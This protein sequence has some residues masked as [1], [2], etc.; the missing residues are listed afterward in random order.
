ML[1]GLLPAQCQELGVM[2][3]QGW[4]SQTHKETAQPGVSDKTRVGVCGSCPAEGEAQLQ[5]L[6]SSPALGSRCL[7][8]T[9]LPR[10]HTGWAPGMSRR[11][12][13]RPWHKAPPGQPDPSGPTAPNPQGPALPPSHARGGAEDPRHRPAPLPDLSAVPSL[14]PPAPPVCP[15]AHSPAEP[16]ASP[17]PPASPRAAHRGGGRWD[18]D[19]AEGDPIHRGAAAGLGSARSGPAQRGSARYDT[20]RSGP[21]WP[22]TLR[23]GWVRLGSARLGSGWAGRGPGPYIWFF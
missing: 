22:R 5:G 3:W 9:A 20:V 8:P 4:S 7:R 11:R 1:G 6:A 17:V 12:Q 16:A 19:Q 2:S 13:H 21:L 18:P 15:S 14:A 23:S 10:H